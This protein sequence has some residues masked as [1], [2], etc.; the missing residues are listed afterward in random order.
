MTSHDVRDMLDLPDAAASRPTKKQKISTQRPTLK[1]LAR[2]VQNLSGD[3]PI[4]IVPEISVFKKRRFASRKPAAKWE[5]RSFKNPAREDDSLTLRHWRRKQETPPAPAGYDGSTDLPDTTNP[6]PEIER[7]AFAKFNV[8]VNVPDYTDDE[9]N[10]RLQNPDWSKEETDYL[11]DL[12]KQ[13]DLRWPVIW[14]R[15]EY[16]PIIPS[17]DVETNQTAIVVTSKVRSM[18]DLKARYYFVAATM[19]MLR[20]PPIQMNTAEFNLHEVMLNFNPGQETLRKKFAEA[21]FRRTKEEA[22]EE[23]SLL[24][25]LKRIL[26]RSEKLNDE[27]RELYARLETPPSTGNIGIYTSSQGL[28]QLLQQLMTVDKT[29]KRKSLMVGDG[30]SPAAGPSGQAQNAN[31]DRRESSVRES[32]TGP[33]GA[34]GKKGAQGP[35]ERR[36]LTEE[37]ERIYGVSRHERLTSGPAFRLER[38]SKPLISKS[39]VQQTKISNVLTELEVPQRLIMPTAEV[40]EA[41]ESVLQSINVLLEARKVADKLAGEVAV[42]KAQKA[43]KEKA[44]RLARGEPADGDADAAVNGTGEAEGSEVKQEEREKSVAASIKGGGAHKRSASVLSAASDKNT[45][46][47]KK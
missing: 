32:T 16:E 34:P 27:R 14:D 38:I 12:A 1:G 9:Y 28:Q 15:Y 46:R 7:S 35:S 21:A 11:M 29:K 4:A 39:A 22:R 47:Q 36:Q 25:E 40:G 41:Y 2:E 17:M 30:V 31:A 23:E 33:S 42:A 26:A 44:A 5:L 24:L 13:F 3:N 8:Q 45:K 6:E 19:M 10:K 43:E 20:K 37:E 18:E